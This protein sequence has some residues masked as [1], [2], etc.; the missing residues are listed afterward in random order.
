MYFTAVP[1]DFVVV[2][3]VPLWF[4]MVSQDLSRPFVIKRRFPR[5]SPMIPSCFVM[6]SHGFA[7]NLQW[8]QRW[9]RNCFKM[10][11]G[12]HEGC[13]NWLRWF[14]TWLR[15]GFMVSRP[16]KTTQDHPRRPKTTPISTQDLHR[17]LHRYRHRRRPMV[18]C[19]QDHTRRPQDHPKTT[20]QD[21]H[22]TTVSR[23]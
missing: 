16:P 19:C 7:V 21:H 9:F 10:V 12:F 2:C 1:L 15:N 23:V 3:A 8:F 22:K 4:P 17:H 13:N 20:T 5:G 11:S 18:L 6:A 14:Q